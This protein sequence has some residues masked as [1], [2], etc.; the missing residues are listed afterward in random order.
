MAQEL[1]DAIVV[2][3]TRME[4]DEGDFVSIIYYHPCGRYYD[5][6]RRIVSRFGIK[7]PESKGFN[8]LE[9]AYNYLASKGYCHTTNKKTSL[10]CKTS[11]WML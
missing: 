10:M 9:E 6:D 3:A 8:L 11:A 5:D 7:A 4:Q 2:A 1:A